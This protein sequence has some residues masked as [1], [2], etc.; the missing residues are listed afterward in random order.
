M[1]E[2]A[3]PADAYYEVALILGDKY[4]A[5]QPP[6]CGF[7]VEVRG[8]DN[9]PTWWEITAEQAEHLHRSLDRRPRRAVITGKVEFDRGPEEVH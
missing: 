9:R 4:F 5:A 7:C 2:G 3:P 8:A 1:A 6:R